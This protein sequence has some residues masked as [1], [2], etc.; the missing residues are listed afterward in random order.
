MEENVDAAAQPDEEMTEEVAQMVLHNNNI[1]GKQLSLDQLRS[2]QD[3]MQFSSVIQWICR[4][5]NVTRQDLCLPM[6]EE[7][8]RRH[9][10]GLGLTRPELAVIAAH[11]KMHI[12]KDLQHIDPAKIPNF[13]D[14]VRS[15]F[16]KLIQERYPTE[17]QE[18]MLRSS[19][20]FTVLLNEVIGEAGC[21]LFP[22]I[23]CPRSTLWCV[24]NSY[25]AVTEKTCV[26]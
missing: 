19:I 18:H 16:P 15:Y 25:V 1:H 11:V 2:E 20:G 4:R 3:P 9:K 10:I 12:F 8:T 17:L 21:W 26:L 6:D 24:Q 22:S 13:R 14:K 7:L 23:C 5:G